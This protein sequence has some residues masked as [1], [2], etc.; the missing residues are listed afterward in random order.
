MTLEG[1]G[2][3]L[4][5]AWWLRW[6]VPH[7]AF[8]TPME[9]QVTWDGTSP[10]SLLKILGNAVPRNSSFTISRTILPGTLSTTI[11]QVKS[12]DG[13]GSTVFL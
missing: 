9:T 7:V 1:E 13:G 4:N 2:M 8:I 11:S 5:S 10:C 6:R 3:G 12:G